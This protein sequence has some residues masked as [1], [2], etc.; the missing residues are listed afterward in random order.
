MYNMIFRSPVI[1][2]F[3][4]RSYV[5]QGSAVLQKK[6]NNDILKCTFTL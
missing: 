1:D 5:N 3:M 2:V 4:Y 6:E